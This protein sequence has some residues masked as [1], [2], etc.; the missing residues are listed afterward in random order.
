V[1]IF[2]QAKSRGWYR[3]ESSIDIGLLKTVRRLTAGIEV[4]QC[5]AKQWRKAIKIGF[6]AFLQ[7]RDHG[8]GDIDVD[9]D[10]QLLRYLSK[11]EREAHS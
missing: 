4:Q 3:D 9:L 6:D 7:L 2:N 10:A 8:G 11:V 1:F 5:T